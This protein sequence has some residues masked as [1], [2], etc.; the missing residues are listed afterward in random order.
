V[1]SISQGA[2]S[3]ESP[4]QKT[5]TLMI[6]ELTEDQL[7][8]SNTTREGNQRKYP[9]VALSWVQSTNEVILRPC[10][11]GVR[12]QEKTKI[13]EFRSKYVL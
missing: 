11:A 2:H 1:S 12:I 13:V 5:G 10:K 4:T 8:E 9:K 3:R 7:E 6:T